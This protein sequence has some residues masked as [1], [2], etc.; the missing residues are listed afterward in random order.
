M[1]ILCTTRV[2]GGTAQVSWGSSALI[3]TSLLFIEPQVTKYQIHTHVRFFY[4]MKKGDLKNKYIYEERI[5]KTSRVSQCGEQCYNRVTLL[6]SQVIGLPLAS[7]YYWL[8]LI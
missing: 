4:S 8:L 5:R 2:Q 1:G 3:A 7:D 6:L